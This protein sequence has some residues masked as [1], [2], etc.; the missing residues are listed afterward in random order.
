VFDKVRFRIVT[1]DKTSLAP[2]LAW[3]QQNLFPFNY[4]IPGESHNNLQSYQNMLDACGF[5]VP[6]SNGVDSS[7]DSVDNP[8]SFSGSSYRVINFII[9][10]PIRVDHLVDYSFSEELGRVLF[11]M[12]EFQIVD[13]ETAHRNEKGDASHDLYKE[14]QQAQV[15]RRLKKGRRRDSIF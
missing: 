6:P 5:Q 10:L 7:I 11:A 12:V 4:V 14:R 3:L 8:N 1:E 15:L 2:I 13:K 9:D